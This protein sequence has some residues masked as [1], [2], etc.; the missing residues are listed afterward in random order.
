MKLGCKIEEYATMADAFLAANGYTRDD[1]TTGVIAWQ[2]AH[3]SGITKDAYALSRD[4]YDA[5][6]QTVLEKIFPKAVF[7]D[8]K[9]Y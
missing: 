5:H 3:G 7:R 1:V 6:I 8:V 4:V 2:V 9:R